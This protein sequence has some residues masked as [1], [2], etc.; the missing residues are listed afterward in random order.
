MFYYMVNRTFVLY[1]IDRIRIGTVF[2]SSYRDLL[3]YY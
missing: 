2:K 1:D 3:F